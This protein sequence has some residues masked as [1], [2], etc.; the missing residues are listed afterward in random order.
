MS[1]KELT[2]ANGKEIKLT[3]VKQGTPAPKR[4]TSGD[5]EFDQFLSNALQVVIK[6]KK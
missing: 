5:K 6:P 2:D 3:V 1:K 4:H